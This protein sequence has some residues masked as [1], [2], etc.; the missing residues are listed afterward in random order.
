M[1]IRVTDPLVF[2]IKI[3]EAHRLRKRGKKVVIMV[4]DLDALCRVYDTEVICDMLDGLS[5]QTVVN[6]KDL[7]ALN[8]EEINQI[9]RN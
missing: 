7:K 3:A 1:I 2:R 5:L 4:D 8:E 9:A 6:E